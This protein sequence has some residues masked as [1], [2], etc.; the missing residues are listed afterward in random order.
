MLGYRI[1]DKHSTKIDGNSHGQVT[2]SGA[3]ADLGLESVTTQA[4]W[5]KQTVDSRRGDEAETDGRATE[6]KLLRRAAFAYTGTAGSDDAQASSPWVHLVWLWAV[7]SFTW[8][9]S[10]LFLAAGRYS[11]F[12]QAVRWNARAQKGIDRCAS[13]HISANGAV[14]C[15]RAKAKSTQSRLDWGGGRRQRP[16]LAAWGRRNPGSGAHAPAQ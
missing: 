4:R 11:Y 16:G 7:V 3:D 8:P 12:G 9:V 15:S 14:G 1:L 2:G 13:C 5:M 10:G 6:T